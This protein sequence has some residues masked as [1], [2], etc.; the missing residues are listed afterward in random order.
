[1]AYLT[2]KEI[3]DLFDQFLLRKDE[4][5]D[6]MAFYHAIRSLFPEIDGAADPKKSSIRYSD[7]LGDEICQRVA[8]GEPIR[9]ILGDSHMPNWD[10]LGKWT[11]KYPEFEKKYDH[12]NKRAAE[13]TANKILELAKKA[14]DDPK[15]AKGYAVAAELLRWQAAI[16]DSKKYS[17][18]I[19]QDVTHHIP[20]DPEK[21]KSEITRL[22]KE[23]GIGL[24]AIK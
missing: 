5:G 10:T 23:L 22:E 15:N 13:W 1:M 17:E 4:L 20:D 7:K 18:K 9:I 12:A 2:D 8:C 21:V 11:K 3:G 24:R 6:E 16:R 19:V 14:E